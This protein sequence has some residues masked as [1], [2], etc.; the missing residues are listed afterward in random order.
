MTTPRRTNY[1]WVSWLARLMAG[2]VSCG[3]AAW[4][5]AHYQAYERAESDGYLALWT[6]QHTRRLDELV[7]E[8]TRLDETVWQ[9]AQAAFR[10][11]LRPTLLLGGR[12]DLVTLDSSGRY[13]VYEVKTGRPRH[14]HTVQTLLYVLCLPL[15]YPQ[16]RGHELAGRVV[17]ADGA[18]IPLPPALANEG[19]RDAARHYVDLVNGLEPPAHVPSPNECKYCDLTNA[20]CARRIASPVEPRLLRELP[21]AWQPLAANAA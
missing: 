11:Q 12:P 21:V 8:R 19:F 9:E 1:L 3:W 4:F 17:Y 10:V 7:A 14:S 2:E 16:L 18:E 5:R 20:D 15:A 13:T 6:V